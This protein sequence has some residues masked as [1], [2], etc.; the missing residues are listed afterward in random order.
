LHRRGHKLGTIDL[1]PMPDTAWPAVV[2]HA[3]DHEALVDRVPK[4]VRRYA[5]RD[6]R[7]ALQ[8]LRLGTEKRTRRFLWDLAHV[9]PARWRARLS[10]YLGNRA[11]AILGCGRSTADTQRRQKAPDRPA[12][13]AIL[14][15]ALLA[16]GQ[17]T[18]R[19]VDSWQ[20][21]AT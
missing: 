21:L 13:A 7:L 18:M 15:W 1:P 9:R 14:F 6:R 11:A 19:K 2:D 5:W 4:Y 3:I 17:I 20:T 8:L 16:S 12:V 10:A